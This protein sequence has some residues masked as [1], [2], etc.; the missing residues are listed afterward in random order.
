[1]SPLAV[2]NAAPARNAP[3]ASGSAGNTGSG[4]SNPDPMSTTTGTPN[5]TN[6]ATGTD[7]VNPDTTKF[8]GCTFNTKPV[9]GPTAAA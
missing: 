3:A 4:A 2:T 8:D 9:S 6:S 5:G 1:M 7:A